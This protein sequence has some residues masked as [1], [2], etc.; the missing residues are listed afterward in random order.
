MH[1]LDRV[2]MVREAIG[3][4]GI[5]GAQREAELIVSHALG[6][7]RAAL[8]RDTNPVPDDIALK[9]DE[10]VRRRASREPLQYI[11]GFVDF[12][13]LKIK[14]GR[15]VL[16]PRPE[17]ELLAEEAIKMFK[18]RNTNPPFPPFAKRGQ[19]GITASEQ[20]P[21][22]LRFLDLCTGSGCLALALAR[23]F[24]DAM[25]YGTDSETAAVSYAE[26]NAKT[27][28]IK[29]VLFLEGSLFEPVEN[30]IAV[31]GERL[32][33]DLIV[34]NPPYIR[35]DDLKKLQPEIRDWEPLT[36]LDGGED[37]L[38]FY[39]EIVHRAVRHLKAH[40]ILLLELG[41]HQSEEV[42]QMAEDAGFRDISVR[43][44]YA[45]IERILIARA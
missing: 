15:G 23:A 18:K 10:I 31:A 33:F 26:E 28:N 12:M 2:K 17:T 5:G 43:K 30:Q 34:S 8:Y 35:R 41:I 1:S 39:R 37:G 3:S 20:S 9:I 6:I 16:I 7:D 40:G 42:K 14:V 45:G 32:F 22:V 25:V 21:T 13:G 19:G 11:L 24:P 29:N 4:A 44:D 36:A 27:N 38:N